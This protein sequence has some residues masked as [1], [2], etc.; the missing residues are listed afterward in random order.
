[1]TWTGDRVVAQFR[2]YADG[3]AGK[4]S[5]TPVGSSPP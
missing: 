4:A 5:S 1:M 2:K 3:Y